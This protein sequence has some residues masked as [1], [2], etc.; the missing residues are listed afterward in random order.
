[1]LEARTGAKRWQ[2]LA[3]FERR[4]VL[5]STTWD[6]RA[7][8]ENALA[9]WPTLLGRTV[10]LFGNEA[11]DAFGV[12]PTLVHPQEYGG[13]TWRQLPHPSGRCHWYNAPKNREVAALL[14][15]ELYLASVG[16]AA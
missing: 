10:V 9:M 4:N 8:R 14:L 11:R 13:V 15:E 12:P 7:A 16:Q 6:R 5:D 3:A 1:M 2:Y